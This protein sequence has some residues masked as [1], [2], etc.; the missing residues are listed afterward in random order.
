LL[1]RLFGVRAIDE[2]H[3][4]ESARSTRFPVDWQHHLR[5]RRDRAEVRAQVCFSGAVGEITDEQTDGQSTV[6]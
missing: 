1:D 4:R 3:E 6:S 2:F 5:G